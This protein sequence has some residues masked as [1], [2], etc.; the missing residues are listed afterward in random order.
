MGS[1]KF[2]KKRNRRAADWAK[3]VVPFIN[4][5]EPETKQQ[6]V[7]LAFSSSSELVPEREKRKYFHSVSKIRRDFILCVCVRVSVSLQIDENGFR[8]KLIL[9]ERKLTN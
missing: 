4:N 3:G 6:I 1:R 2:K 7:R 9:V 5:K 8:Q